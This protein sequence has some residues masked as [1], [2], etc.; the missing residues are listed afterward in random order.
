[1]DIDRRRQ[2]ASELHRKPRLIEHDEIPPGIVKA[3]EEFIDDDKNPKKE[4]FQPSFVAVDG[5][6]RRREVDYS[7]VKKGCFCFVPEPQCVFLIWEF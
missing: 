4:K 2:E 1:M 6:R 3:S 5:P 7:Q